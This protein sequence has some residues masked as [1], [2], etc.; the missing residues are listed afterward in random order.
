MAIDTNVLPFHAWAKG[1]N[2][3][4]I[5]KISWALYE[6]G[7]VL[8]DMQM[9][10]RKTLLRN[11][12]RWEGNLPSVDFVAINQEPV[13]TYGTPTQRQEAAH[14]IR[15]FIEIDHVL[16]EDENNISDPAAQQVKAWTK[17]F[18]YKFNDYA[19]NNNHIT[20][21]AL[22][23][24]GWRY[25]LDNPTSYG[26]PTEMKIDGGSVDITTGAVTAATA[27]RFLEL[28]GT[29]LQRMDC[30]PSN[31]TIYCNDIM[32]LRFRTVIAAL[33][34]GAGFD[35]TKDNYDRKVVT[36]NGAK[37]KN[38][39]RKADQTTQII[40]TEDATGADSSG[41]NYTSLYFVNHSAEGFSGWQF[42][43]MQAKPAFI[44]DTG[45][46][47]RTLLE[48]IFGFWCEDNRCLARLYDL[49]YV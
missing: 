25:R 22:G 47:K 24:V 17:G 1:T 44:D 27:N 23:N 5:T 12:A 49:K 16:E 3:P 29:A 33:A 32:E 14:L 37:I 36:Y 9:M 26:I 48:Y 6:R 21:D 34:A 45:V 42:S 18:T 35:T 30:D 43:P 11:G 2:N 40:K 31:V 19:V 7:N 13:V 8:T 20:G 39:G 38:I 10:N 15:N 41:S 46:I 4:L 28:V